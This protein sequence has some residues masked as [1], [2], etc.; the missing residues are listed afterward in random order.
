M[1]LAWAVAW[2]AALWWLAALATFAASLLGALL[3][4]R[5]QRGRAVA[6]VTPPASLL[7]PVKL[8]D[9]GFSRAQAS[10]FAQDLPAY[11][12]IVTA[13]EAASP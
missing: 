11:E 10:A 6:G 12:V 7:M 2:L 5:I 8:V 1:T 9:P 3:Q 13:A 4:P